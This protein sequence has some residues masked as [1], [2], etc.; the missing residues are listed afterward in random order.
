MKPRDW[1]I[2]GGVALAAWWLYKKATAIP[3]ALTD[4]GEA[5]GGQ[6]FDWFNPNAGGAAVTYIVN[7]AGGVKHA[8]NSNTVD[9]N[10]LFT[11]N[12]VQFKMMNDAAGY[13]Y[14]TT[15]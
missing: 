15:P 7:F 6:L 3:Q 2:L 4:A 12:G 13:H 5:I 1:I 9:S 14:A 10:G 11:Y 8:I